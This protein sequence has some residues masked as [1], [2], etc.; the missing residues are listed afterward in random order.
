MCF[1]G[2]HEIDVVLQ[3]RG[4]E[5]AQHAVVV[6]DVGHGQHVLQRNGLSADEVRSS[7]YAHKGHLLRSVSLDGAFQLLQVE[8]ALEGVVALG[9][10]SLLANQL[11]YLAA[12][13]GNVR[14]RG[15]EVEVHDG[16]HAWLD[17]G[18]GQD[19]LAGATLVS[20]QYVVGAKHLFDSGAEA[21]KGFTASV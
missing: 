10:Q 7:L 2:L 13:A 18:F 6:A 12:A 19:I 4:V 11:E 5:H 3:Q 14:F 8:V 20:G 9:L 15:G 16:Y 21:V 17:E 1:A